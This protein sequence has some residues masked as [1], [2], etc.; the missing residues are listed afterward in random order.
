MYNIIE[1]LLWVGNAANARD[2]R[3]LNDNEIRA[4]VDVAY[5]EAPANVPRAMIYVRVP[6]LDGSGNSPTH[7][8]FAVKSLFALISDGQQTLISCSAGM[9]RSVAIAAMSW[10]LFSH[11]NPEE[12][13]QSIAT[14]HPHDVSSTFWQELNETFQSSPPGNKDL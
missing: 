1:N 10:A 14:H 4:V 7:L 6:L 2:A 13:L 12:M 9:S 5:E 8:R 3:L 11:R